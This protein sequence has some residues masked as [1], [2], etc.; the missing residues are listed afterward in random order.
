MDDR[1]KSIC[2]DLAAG[3][4][5]TH[6]KAC[7]IEKCLCECKEAS[8]SHGVKA[9]NPATLAIILELVTQLLD[10]WKRRNP[11]PVG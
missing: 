2:E 9:I 6:E 1:L 8:A 4:E 7:E 11:V 3:G 10:W 5:M